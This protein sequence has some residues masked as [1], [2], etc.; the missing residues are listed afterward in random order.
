MH[1]LTN[2]SAK[3]PSW[4]IFTLEIYSAKVYVATSPDLIRTLYG[5]TKSLSFFPFTVAFTER[6]LG[7]R[8]YVIDALSANGSDNEYMHGIHGAY[9]ALSPGPDLIETNRRALNSLADEFNTIGTFDQSKEL[10]QWMRTSYAISLS[11]AFYG[12]DNPILDNP[13]F[14]QLIW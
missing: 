9:S 8:K 6:V 4:P 5:T 14:I 13:S 3:Y 2:T 12:P 10:L 7:A 1:S 11:K